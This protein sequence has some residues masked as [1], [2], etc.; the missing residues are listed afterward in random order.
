M[1]QLDIVTPTKKLVSTEAN[2]VNIPGYKGELGILPEHTTLVTTLD[3]G[4]VRYEQAGVAKKV[5]V[6][7]GFAKV[8]RNRI[9][10]LA[11]EGVRD[12]DAKPDELERKSA[13]LNRK[14]IAPEIGPDEREKLFVER[15]WLNACLQLVK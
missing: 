9:M 7:G 4:V 3:V 8:S 15:L 6:K 13:E 14:L 2:A 10:L 12:S 11:D 1:I 5:A